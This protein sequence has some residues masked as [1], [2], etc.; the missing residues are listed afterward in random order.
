M[1]NAKL[2]PGQK[3]TALGLKP[4]IIATCGQSNLLLG[5]HTRVHKENYGFP[6]A[7]VLAYGKRTSCTR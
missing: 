3:R 1:I 5:E 4:V 2:G 6:L 7:S